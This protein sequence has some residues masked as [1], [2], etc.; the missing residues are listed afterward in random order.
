MWS[1]GDSAVSCR[2]S[3]QVSQLFQ[4]LHVELWRL[5]SQL[6]AIPPGESALAAVF[7]TICVTDA[8]NT[9]GESHV[10]HLHVCEVLE[11]VRISAAA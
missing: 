5:H 11:T 9:L 4:Q 7:L 1:F 8:L 10:Y 2:L 6:P 3:L